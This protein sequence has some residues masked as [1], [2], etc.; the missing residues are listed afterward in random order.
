MQIR[1]PQIMRIKCTWSEIA[2]SYGNSMF[3]FLRDRWTIFHSGYTILRSHQQCMMFQFF[4]ILA[5]ICSLPPFL[6]LSS[7]DYSYPSGCQ[8]VFHCGFNLHSLIT[9]DV[10]HLFY[11]RISHLDIFFRKISIPKLCLFLN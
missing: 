10:E 2:V 5:N 7:F 1:N 3:N 8:V 4:H 6:P 11:V 9:S